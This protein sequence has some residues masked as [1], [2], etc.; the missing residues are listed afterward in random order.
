MARVARAE[1]SFLP[2]VAA[3]AP[4]DEELVQRIVRG[5]RWAKEALYRRYF[6]LV[7]R[8]AQRLLGD[9]EDAEDVTQ[10]VFAVALEEVCDLKKGAALKAWLLSVTFHQAHRR[11]RRRRLR[12][13]LGLEVRGEPV[14]LDK[15][16]RP[17]VSPEV[18]AELARL[19]AVLKKLSPMKRFAWLLRRVDG[20]SLLEVAEAC[21]CSLATV[22][23]HLQVAD[24]A[25][26]Q[27]VNLAED[28]HD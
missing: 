1:H 23:R 6:P 25:V 24:E 14:E 11:F 22:K 21:N 13:L 20:C 12:R 4:S 17:G 28:D 26:R 18:R 7:W 10:D 9:R 5:D 16:A 2:A 3:S 19:D 27:H 8:T 15:L